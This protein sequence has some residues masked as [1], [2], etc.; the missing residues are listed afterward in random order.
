MT[1]YLVAYYSWTGA[2]A[3]IAKLL[4]Q[5][6]SADLEEI[7]DA[8]RRAGPFAFVGAVFESLGKRPARILPAVRDPADYDVVILGCPVWAQDIASPMRAY[9]REQGRK[10]R[11]VALFCTFGGA[12]GEATLDKLS[13]LCGLT[14]LARLAVDDPALKSERWRDMA[15]A[16]SGQLVAK[17]AVPA[18]GVGV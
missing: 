3:K 15:Q 18:Q 6:L 9:V 7:R 4:A 17:A 2:T 14:P 11:K 1:R 8:R 12:G 10:F 16:F 5:E 13:A